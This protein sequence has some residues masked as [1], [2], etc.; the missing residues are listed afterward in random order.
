MS[1]MMARMMG[2][3][4]KR[5]E[6][7]TVC[8]NGVSFSFVV[9]ESSYLVMEGRTVEKRLDKLHVRLHCL[10]LPTRLEFVVD[11]NEL[12]NAILQK[13]P[14]VRVSTSDLVVVSAFVSG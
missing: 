7:F 4:Q 2:C 12:S 10:N 13:R 1:E 9:T 11:R 8:R 14:R 6:P 3:S 5:G